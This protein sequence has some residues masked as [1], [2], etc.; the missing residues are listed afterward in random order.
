MAHFVELDET[1]IVIRGIVVH[2]NELL[3]ENNKESE[4]KGIQFCKS[5]FGEDTR[6]IQTSYN[7]NFRKNF[8]GPG[9]TYD[10]VR[11]AFIPEKV[12]RSWILDEETCIWKAPIPRP[13]DGKE[14]DW[15]EENTQWVLYVEEQVS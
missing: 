14:Y 2:D 6:W 11:D 10:A 15:D 4:E 12:F 8:A 7:S 9:F 3:D 5:L 13:D 1:N